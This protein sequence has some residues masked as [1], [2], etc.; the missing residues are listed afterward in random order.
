MGDLAQGCSP[1]YWLAWKWVLSLLLGNFCIQIASKIFNLPLE[2]CLLSLKLIIFSSKLFYIRVWGSTEAL[3]DEINSIARLL[4]L[5]I[6]SDKDL[7]E[8]VNDSCFLKVGS[9]FLLLC[10]CSLYWCHSIF[11]LINYKSLILSKYIYNPYN[12][13][14]IC[15]NHGVLGFWGFGVL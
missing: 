4:W 8:L 5:L 15:R 11:Y 12:F 10:L 9:K 6:K 7:S 14:H 1:L 13:Y 2:L 3:L